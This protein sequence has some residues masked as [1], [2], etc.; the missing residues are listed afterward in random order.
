MM[1]VNVCV[2]FVVSLSCLK[3]QWMY[4]R[5]LFASGLTAECL[6]CVNK[7]RRGTSNEVIVDPWLKE[8]K[9]F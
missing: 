1:I 8:K 7:E 9:S 5:C 2:D 6:W 4:V 3:T